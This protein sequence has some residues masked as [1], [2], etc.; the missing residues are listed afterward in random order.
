MYFNAAYHED[1]ALSDGTHVG[2]RLIRHDDKWRLRQIFAGLSLRSRVMRFFIPRGELSERELGHLTELDGIDHFAL[3]A[4]RGDESLGV[5]RFVRQ[6]PGSGVAEPAVAVVDSHQS[7]GLGRILVARLA[8]AAHE[9]GIARFEAEVLPQNR[10]MLR[11][12]HGLGGSVARGPSSPDDTITC[13]LDLS[14]PPHRARHLS[15]VA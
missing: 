3:L 12:L 14:A 7:R 4:V 1:V 15:R 6:M 9:R 5:A 2:L 10:A 8:A 11:L 13:T